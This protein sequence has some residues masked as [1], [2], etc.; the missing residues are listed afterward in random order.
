MVHDYPHITVQ[1]KSPIYPK[2]PVFVSIAPVACVLKII[3]LFSQVYGFTIRDV[4]VVILG[5]NGEDWELGIIEVTSR[6]KHTMYVTN[7]TYIIIQK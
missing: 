5:K 7:K 3:L 4:K 2:Q 1:H 6:Y